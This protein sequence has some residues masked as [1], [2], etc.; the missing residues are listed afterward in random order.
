MH[1][2]LFSCKTISSVE[3]QSG[4]LWVDSAK[5]ELA[6]ETGSFWRRKAEKSKKAK[7]AKKK[8]KKLKKLKKRKQWKKAKTEKRPENQNGKP[9]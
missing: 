4:K 7:K 8:R 6:S 2:H 9:K 1:T 3:E 5:R